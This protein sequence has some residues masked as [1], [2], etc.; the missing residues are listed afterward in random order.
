M[1]TWKLN[2]T[3]FTQFM[4]CKKGEWFESDEMKHEQIGLSSK[5]VVYPKGYRTKA[6]LCIFLTVTGNSDYSNNNTFKF[7]IH[8]NYKNTIWNGDLLLKKETECVPLQ[9]KLSFDMF[10]N[11]T[12]KYL[13]FTWSIQSLNNNN[14]NYSDHKDEDVKYSEMDIAVIPQQIQPEYNQYMNYNS[15]QSNPDIATFKWIINE[16]HKQYILSELS[17]QQASS[18]LFILFGYVCQLICFSN[19]DKKITLHIAPIKQIQNI[20]IYHMILL[21]DMNCIELNKRYSTTVKLTGINGD[22]RSP[23]WPTGYII[24]NDIINV[25]TITFTLKFKMLKIIYESNERNKIY[26]G[27]Y[28]GKLHQISTFKLYRDIIF[29]WKFSI[30]SIFWN[31]NNGQWLMSDRFNIWQLECFPNGVNN[32]TNKFTVGLHIALFPQHEYLDIFTN[33]IEVQIIFLLKQL[34][35][36]WKQVIVFGKNEK[37]HC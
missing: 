19:K 16:Y 9:P 18:D 21:V 34:N 13:T 23:L 5:I 28:T 8:C 36:E 32:E 30:N 24:C 35:Y 1:K 15:M 20:G 12:L 37:C 22:I 3:D 7:K 29:N 27:P 11:H 31:M 25:S 4:H 26:C 14:I 33:S 6:S 10:H 17:T 2:E